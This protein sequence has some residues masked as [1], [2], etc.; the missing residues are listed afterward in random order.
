[1]IIDLLFFT[2]CVD[3]PDL[4][5]DDQ[6]AVEIELLIQISFLLYLCIFRIK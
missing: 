6:E 2:V 5:L 4:T 1:M 3:K